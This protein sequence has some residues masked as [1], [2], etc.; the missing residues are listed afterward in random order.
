MKRFAALLVLATALVV[1][2][3]A[4]ATSLP[5]YAGIRIVHVHQR[6]GSCSEQGRSSQAQRLTKKIAPVACEQPPR[7]KLRNATTVIFFGP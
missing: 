6:R 5:P 7:P 1:P 4:A 2:A 3:V